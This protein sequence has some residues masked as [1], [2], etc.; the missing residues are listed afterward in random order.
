MHKIIIAGLILGIA[1]AS[2]CNGNHGS[3]AE[4]ALVAPANAHD[5]DA[6][7]NVVRQ[8]LATEVPKGSAPPYNYVVPPGDSTE[9]TRTRKEEAEGLAVLIEQGTLP[10]S[11]VGIGGSDP[12]ATAEVVIQALDR[13]TPGR[14]KGLTIV[15]I[16]SGQRDGELRKK[17]VTSGAELKIKAVSA[18]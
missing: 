9:A 16:G 13:V 3:S 8:G 7:G 18:S 12:D 6:W 14:A 15:V 1:V 11:A 5:T 2:G 10:G 17:V 4:K